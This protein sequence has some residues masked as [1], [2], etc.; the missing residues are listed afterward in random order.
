[1]HFKIILFLQGREEINEMSSKKN[2]TIIYFSFAFSFLLFS[3]PCIF[4]FPKTKH[5][6]E[7]QK[8]RGKS[9]FSLTALGCFP[10][11]QP[12]TMVRVEQIRNQGSLLKKGL[13]LFSL[14]V[15]HFFLSFSSFLC[16]LLFEVAKLI[17]SVVFEILN[18]VI[19]KESC[20]P[21]D[22]L[23]SVFHVNYLYWLERNAGIISMG[24]SDDCRP[25][26]RL[27]ISLEYVQREFNHLKNDSEFVG[28]ATDGLIA[29]PLPNRIRPGHV[30][31]TPTS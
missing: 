27:Q 15:L 16:F 10:Y 19:L 4:L 18:Q 8:T 9:E 7:V 6:V 21:Q 22:M 30:A 13:S 24:A 28:W 29:R 5:G 20:S 3:F 31:S 1:M 11:L 25:G 17:L 26:G 23:K 14:F 12:I 2:E